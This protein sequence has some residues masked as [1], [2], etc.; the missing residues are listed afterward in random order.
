MCFESYAALECDESCAR[1]CWCKSG[2]RSLMSRWK[3]VSNSVADTRAHCSHRRKSHP[4][5]FGW[6]HW[7]VARTDAF[8]SAHPACQLVVIIIAWPPLIGSQSAVFLM[9]SS[10]NNTAGMVA[11]LVGGS[12]WPLSGVT[13]GDHS[14]Q[15]VTEN[16]LGLISNAPPPLFIEVNYRVNRS[17][18]RILFSIMP[19]SAHRSRL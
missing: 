4:P 8:E 14:F 12:G 11:V 16:E 5:R 6:D 15:P 13:A 2:C 1:C 18:A 3:R 19:S 9:Y 17:L 10:T 7:L